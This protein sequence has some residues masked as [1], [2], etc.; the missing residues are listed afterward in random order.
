MSEVT[1][2]APEPVIQQR[3]YQGWTRGETEE[4][5]RLRRA[6][7]TAAQIARNLSR[8]RC[9]VIGKLHRLDLIGGAK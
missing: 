3:Y 6:G 5:I 9:S 4:A 1:A 2:S 7:Y 8:S